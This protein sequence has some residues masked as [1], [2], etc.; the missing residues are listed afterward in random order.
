MHQGRS[1][2]AATVD[3]AR[4]RAQ[5]IVLLAGYLL[6]SPR[7]RCPGVDGSTA[8]DVVTAEYPGAAAVGWVPRPA[9]LAVRHPDLASAIASVFPAGEPHLGTAC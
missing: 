2:P 6:A 8:A 3:A 1:N 9:D 4:A 7:F 5:A